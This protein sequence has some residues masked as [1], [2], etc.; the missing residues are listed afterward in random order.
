MSLTG[1]IRIL[2]VDDHAVLREGIAAVIT[3]EPDMELVGEAADGL[4]AVE[5]FRLL[6][7]DVTLL[8]LQMPVLNGIEALVQ[9]RSEFPDARVVVLTT[10]QGDVQVARALKAGAMSYVLKNYVHRDLLESIRAAHAG[11]KRIPVELAVTLADNIS[12][13]GLSSREVDV[14]RLVAEG[15][16]N[17]EIA[18]RLGISDET[19]KSHVGNIIAKLG[20]NDRTHAV[21]IGLKRGIIEV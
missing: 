18:S 13:N 21:I 11:Q 2:A 17:K 3:A 5:K 7:P 16:S 20:A 12:Q 10:Y 9:I 6:R 15:N 1:P 14:L 4:E 8:D 19:A